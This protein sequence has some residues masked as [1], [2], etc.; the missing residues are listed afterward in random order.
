MNFPSF[1]LLSRWQAL[2]AVC[3]LSCAGCVPRSDYEALQKE[4]QELQK[5]VDSLHVQTR[6]L[7]A[8]LIAAQQQQAVVVE[9]QKRLEDKKKEV[10]EK[11]EEMRQ[12]Q[13]RWEKFKGDRRKAMVGRQFGEV[14]IGDG[15]VLKNAQITGFADDMVSIRHEAGLVKVPIAHGGEEL[16]WLACFDD[17]DE[18]DSLRRV[19]LSQAKAL[20][21]QL[22]VMRPQA[23]DSSGRMPSSSEEAAMLRQTITTQRQSLNAAYQRLS[24]ENASA[25]RG[26]D[27]N[28]TRPEE[29]GLINVF[30]QR[31]ALL[32]LGELDSLAAAIKANL[33]KLHDLETK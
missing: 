14:A 11:E 30:A 8:Q 12:L 4:N 27:W 15:R 32:G 24:S 17:Q 13:E 28:S 10:A 26:V 16:R 22:K 1:I 5:S 7:Q 19:R 20:A 21:E 3:L 29:S 25:L 9:L 2:M 31:R 33:R 18:A 6:Q 23:V